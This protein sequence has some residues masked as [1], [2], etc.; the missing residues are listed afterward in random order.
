MDVSILEIRNAKE[1]MID[2]E[3]LNGMM[4]TIDRLLAGD[5]RTYK[6]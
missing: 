4:P 1:L 6:M 2:R 5:I 3:W